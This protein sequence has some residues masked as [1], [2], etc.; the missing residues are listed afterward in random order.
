MAVK[1]RYDFF[2]EKVIK[3]IRKKDQGDSIV[4]FYLQLLL[5]SARRKYGW[6]IYEHVSETPYHEIA[7]SFN[8]DPKFVSDAIEI[9]SNYGLCYFVENDLR[10]IRP[11]E[12]RSRNTP[13][14]IAWRTAVFERDKYTCQRCG[15]RG[16]R[17]EAHHVKPW[18]EYP[19]FRY[20]VSNGITMCEKCHKGEHSRRRE[21]GSEKDV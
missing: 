6:I 7:L 21:Y 15:K 10:I 16:V 4:V 5:S 17:L 8:L 9:L 12:S 14:Y 1:L 18:A 13:E 3:E 11:H 2:E 19:E 20:D